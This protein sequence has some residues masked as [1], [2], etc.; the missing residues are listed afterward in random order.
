MW[1]GDDIDGFAP[2]NRQDGITFF[3]VFDS[4]S[5]TVAPLQQVDLDHDMFCPGIA[6]QPDG[7]VTVVGG[8]AFGDGAMSTSIWTGS[9]WVSGPKLNIARGY[10]TAV[11]MSNGEVSP[12]S[13]C[14]HCLQEY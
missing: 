12:F 1:S 11:T 4:N 2:Q 7:D 13:P 5:D 6:I 3:T 10:N 8:S 9:N 14:A